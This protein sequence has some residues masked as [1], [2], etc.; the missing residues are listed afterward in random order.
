MAQTTH[1]TTLGRIEIVDQPEEI[2]ETS[3]KKR[4]IL[5]LALLIG[6]LVT[7][8]ALRSRARKN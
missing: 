7:F 1:E 8:L 4:S 3:R 6:A 5:P 2:I